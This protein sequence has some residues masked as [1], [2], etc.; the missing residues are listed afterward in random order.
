MTYSKMSCM[1]PTVFSAVSC[2]LV[3]SGKYEVKGR[4]LTTSLDRGRSVSLT[5]HA[6]SSGTLLFLITNR[7][8]RRGKSLQKAVCRASFL[9]CIPYEQLGISTYTKV[10][11]FIFMLSHTSRCPSRHPGM[12]V[13]VL[14]LGPP[15]GLAIRHMHIAS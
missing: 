6:F 2:C 13:K 5:A 12:V 9:W 10:R 8:H 14:P 15:L 1:M 3:F 11:H 4:H 7:R